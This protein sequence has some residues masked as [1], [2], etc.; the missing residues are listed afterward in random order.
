M[1]DIEAKGIRLAELCR[2]LR[3]L[4]TKWNMDTDQYNKRRREIERE[5]EQ[6]ARDVIEMSRAERNV[7]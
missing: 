2:E 6:L 3:D 7:Q 1:T 4:W 5:T